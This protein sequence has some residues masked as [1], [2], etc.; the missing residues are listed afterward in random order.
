MI[1]TINE[2]K[3]N[4]QWI[5]VQG[6]VANKEVESEGA[7]RMSR[8]GDQIDG[9]TEPKERIEQESKPSK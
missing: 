8:K 4:N 6:E 2:L 1:E 7:A 3:S 9:V 5:E